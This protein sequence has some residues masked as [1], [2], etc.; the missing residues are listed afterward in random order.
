MPGRALRAAP[1][2]PVLVSILAVAA[3][4]SSVVPSNPP[5]EPSASAAWGPL[6]LATC[7]VRPPPGPADQVPSGAGDS[8]NTADAGNGRWRLC[9]QTPT[10]VSL[11]G[12]AICTWN[13]ARTEVIEVDGLPLET[14]RGIALEGGARI[15][16]GADVFLQRV[17]SNGGDQQFATYE[18]ADPQPVRAVSGGRSG[19]GAFDLK[20]SQDPETTVAGSPPRLAGLIGWTCGVPPRPE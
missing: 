7:A 3:C 11:E 2:I 8:F 5:A 18:S 16:D 4:G 15:G 13:P 19:I 20:V 10:A 6:D 14:E 17:T 12:S 1:S 9:L